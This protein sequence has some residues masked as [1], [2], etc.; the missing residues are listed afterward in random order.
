MF[1]GQKV[2]LFVQLCW[3]PPLTPCK[4]WTS[5]GALGNL[6]M[7]ENNM[8]LS[9]S[10][11]ASHLTLWKKKKKSAFCLKC[12]TE[13]NTGCWLQ[14]RLWGNHSVCLLWA[15]PKKFDITDKGEKKRRRKLKLN[16]NGFSP[17]SYHSAIIVTLSLWKIFS[18]IIK[19]IK[20]AH[21]KESFSK[22]S[23]HLLI[24]HVMGCS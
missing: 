22:P 23:R 15:F 4:K 3:A 17:N 6:A 18:K 11:P 20:E 2:Q 1:I 5:H 9:N 19:E 16:F 10:E 7:G 21:F 12:F 8:V 24:M 13:S 14:E